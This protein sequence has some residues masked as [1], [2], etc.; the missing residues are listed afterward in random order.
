MEELYQEPA[1]SA[2]ENELYGALVVIGKFTG[3]Y[4]TIVPKNERE[5]PW[6]WKRYMEKFNI[7]PV[8]QIFDNIKFARLFKGRLYFY[9][10]AQ[11]YFETTFLIQV[12]LRRIG[13][14]FYRIPFMVFF[15]K[16]LKKNFSNIDDVLNVLRGDLLTEEE[17]DDVIEFGRLTAGTWEK[18][19]EKEIANKIM[20]VY[21]GFFRALYKIFQ[22]IAE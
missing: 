8:F 18:G 22:L 14:N 2:L 13:N 5:S 9:V 1:L 10:H 21:E 20:E 6:A 11:K 16:K 17:A 12:E 7:S 15:K 4:L 3:K 19:K